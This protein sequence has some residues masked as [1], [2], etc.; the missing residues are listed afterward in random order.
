MQ[1]L[2]QAGSWVPQTWR[3]G[4][5]AALEHSPHLTH[6]SPGRRVGLTNEVPVESHPPCREPGPEM[7]LDPGTWSFWKTQP[8]SEPSGSPARA[9]TQQ[10]PAGAL[11]RCAARPGL[12]VASPPGI[13][14]TVDQK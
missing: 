9:H 1:P 10:G 5:E 6:P 14:P 3:V 13:Q 8:S 11:T 4:W 12:K 7:S 2:L